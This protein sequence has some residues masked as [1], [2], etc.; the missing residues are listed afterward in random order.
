[1]LRKTDLTRTI[2]GPFKT[3]EKVLDR[4]DTFEVE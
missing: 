2:D 4:R 1:M 3:D